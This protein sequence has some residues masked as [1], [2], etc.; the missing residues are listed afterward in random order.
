MFWIN[1][2]SIEASMG[3]EDFSLNPPL[4]ILADALMPKLLPSIGTG[5][6]VRGTLHYLF[7]YWR[8][9][10][11]F[12]CFWCMKLNFDKKKSFSIWWE[13]KGIVKSRFRCLVFLPVYRECL[14]FWHWATHMPQQW[15]ISQGRNAINAIHNT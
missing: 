15:E 8:F 6:G 11:V 5:P 13:N 9:F 14:Q 10:I 4:T 2:W 1:S 12:C 3:Q 7:L